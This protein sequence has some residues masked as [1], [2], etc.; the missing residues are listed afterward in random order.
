M[1][2][3][4]RPAADADGVIEMPKSLIGRM[5]AIMGEMK[6]LEKSGLN[7]FYGYKYV[8]DSDLLEPLRKIM[9]KY[10]VV[11]FSEVVA[12]TRTEHSTK[13]G[14]STM[15]KLDMK[16]TLACEEG[17][18][19]FA[20]IGYGDDAGE[21]GAYKAMTGGLKTFL[22]KQFGLSGDEDPERDDE[23]KTPPSRVARAGVK[24]NASYDN[25]PESFSEPSE[26]PRAVQ[27]QK[28]SVTQPVAKGGKSFAATD[29]Q[30]REIASEAQRLGLGLIE[31]LSLAKT[32]TGKSVELP[33]DD[34][35][36][37]VAARAFFSGLTGEEAG[38][39]LQM[40]V[41][42]KRMAREAEAQEEKLAEDDDAPSWPADADGQ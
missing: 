17:E 1:P 12:E 13:Q 9:A 23:D 18:R 28:S 41:E 15:T 2:P 33:E 39:I 38:K 10:G 16:M 11:C 31:L 35:D 6:Q 21:K 25:T 14:A 22:M 4:A 42:T 5:A 37:P 29:V 32:V 27:V 7:K 34:K 19:E 36:K 26:A 24:S 20:W 40:L 8:Q 3:S 30:I